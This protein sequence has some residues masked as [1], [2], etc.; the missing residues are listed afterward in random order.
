MTGIVRKVDGLGR[1]IIPKEVRNLRGIQIGD[2]LE[3]FS[4]KDTIVL[5]KYET[6]LP[7]CIV[8]KSLDNLLQA[9]D[10][11]ICRKCAEEIHI[12]KSND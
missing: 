4:D 10:T 12:A 9:K 7:T 1:V 5:I 2:S 8:C 3:F 6:S 11:T